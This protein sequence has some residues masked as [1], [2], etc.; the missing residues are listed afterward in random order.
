V[1]RHGLGR[2]SDPNHQTP[3][4]GVDAINRDALRDDGAARGVRGRYVCAF[5]RWRQPGARAAITGN[6]T[7]SGAL[8]LG[9]ARPLGSEVPALLS[10]RLVNGSCRNAYFLAHY[11]R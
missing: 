11:P 8:T 4:D 7:P 2:H 9:L 5:D 10:A 6:E 3:A 1:G